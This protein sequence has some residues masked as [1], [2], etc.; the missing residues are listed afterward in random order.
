M[1]TWM[2][3]LESIVVPEVDAMVVSHCQ[4]MRDLG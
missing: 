3:L 1:M 4:M 2:L